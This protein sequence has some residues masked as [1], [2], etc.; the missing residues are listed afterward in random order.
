M[1][2]G[3]WL[4]PAYLLV[5][6]L[7][8]AILA[9][10]VFDLGQWYVKMVQSFRLEKTAA[11]GWL[12]EKARDSDFARY[13]NRAFLIAALAW[14][15]PFAKLAGVRKSD[16]GLEPNPVK[17]RDTACGFL[18]AAGLL[19]AMGAV[20]FK[21]G[22]YIDNPK[23]TFT[24]G[25][26]GGSVFAA[27]CVALLEEWFFRGAL[28][29]FLLRSLRPVA[30]TL[31]LAAFFSILHLLQPPE[32]AVVANPTWTS[33]FWMIGQIFGKFSNAS[34]VVAE[35]CTLFLVGLILSYTRLRTQSLWLAIGL[36]AGWVFGV[37]TFG[38][39]VRNGK[40]AL[41]ADWSLWIGKDLKSGLAPLLVLALTGGFV[42]LY[43][44]NRKKPTKLNQD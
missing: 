14:L 6:L 36:H 32:T 10:L 33:G 28:F 1:L 22:R 16:L 39:L 23:S 8:G 11:L 17:W 20:F 26:V 31:F 43:L 24:A 29:G 18:L 21:L 13:F 2:R 27:A 3:P 7:T 19:L 12:A 30:A 15:W 42:G 40:K 25:L 4:L 5:V 38:S 34:F 41:V 37:K 9:P 35:F 44:R